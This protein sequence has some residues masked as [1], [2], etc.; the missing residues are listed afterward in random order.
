MQSYQRGQAFDAYQLC[1]CGATYIQHEN[2]PSPSVG[3]QPTD[4][5]PSITV[6]HHLPSGNNV[7]STLSGLLPRNLQ[8]IPQPQPSNVMSLRNQIPIPGNLI[9]AQE[10][11]QVVPVTQNVAR[12]RVES[13]QAT[14]P[15]Y[16]QPTLLNPT[17][18]PRRGRGRGSSRGNGPSRG[19]SQ[20]PYPNT[21]SLESNP[22]SINAH[23]GFMPVLVSPCDLSSCSACLTTK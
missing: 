23:V 8:N 21:V 15:Q 14:L 9:P 20:H 17:R 6:D 4:R 11:S 2:A 3:T 5:N 18:V 13:M 10:Q 7:A 16:Q 22:T 12:Q 19:S 1:L